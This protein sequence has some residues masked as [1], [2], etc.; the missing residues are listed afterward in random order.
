M[1]QSEVNQT[2]DNTNLGPLEG[3][4]F[5]VTAVGGGGREVKNGRTRLYFPGSGPQ[6]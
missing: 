1:L 5:E 2:S 6:G 4:I 3:E